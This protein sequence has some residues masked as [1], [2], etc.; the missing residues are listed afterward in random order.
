MLEKTPLGVQIEDA[1]K[2]EILSGHL[3][4]G[5]RID[6]EQYA[7]DWG[8]SSTPIRDALTRLEKIGFVKIVPRRGVYVAQIDQHTFKEIF[9]V[10]IALECMATELA[11]PLIPNEEVERVRTSYL[12]AEQHARDSGDRSLLV[13]T[14]YNVHE[15]VLSHCGN[16]KL[17]EIMQDLR[18]MIDWTRQVTVTHVPKSYERTLPEHVSIVEAIRARDV[19]R[20]VRAM[21]HHLTNSY[22][23]TRTYWTT[24]ATRDDNGTAL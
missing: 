23:R 3:L 12:E 15:M 24:S 6:L 18:D 21:R 8:V 11:T 1:L 7:S 17:I 4:P 22:E 5:Q 13:E 20:A 9:D 16:Q 19:E 14:D 10:R 2:Q